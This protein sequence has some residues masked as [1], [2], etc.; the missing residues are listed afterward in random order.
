MLAKQLGFESASEIPRGNLFDTFDRA[1][2]FFHFFPS[3]ACF[4]REY[5]LSFLFPH[6]SEKEVSTQSINGEFPQISTESMLK[7][8]SPSPPLGKI[9]QDDDDEEQMMYLGRSARE[10]IKR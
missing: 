1:L 3:F 5:A 8:P 10:I 6:Q 2:Y 4:E 9:A 7:I